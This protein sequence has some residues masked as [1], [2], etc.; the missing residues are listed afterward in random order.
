M[1]RVVMLQSLIV[2]SV[3]ML[4]VSRETRYG[5][6]SN[7]SWRPSERCMRIKRSSWEGTSWMLSREFCKRY[8]V[9]SGRTSRAL[10]SSLLGSDVLTV[11]VV[12]QLRAFEKLLHDYPEWQGQV[13][14]IQVTSPALT[15]SPKLE[16]Q[17]S[18]LVAHIN[19][20][21]G[22]LDFIPVHH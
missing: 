11:H 3:S 15:D 4:N 1:Y 13:V 17:V 6:V 16:R 10:C 5:R 18:E 19:G 9:I 21:Y 22:S 8:V 7:P 14:L 2:R 20:E 12:I